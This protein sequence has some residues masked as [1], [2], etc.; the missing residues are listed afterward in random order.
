MRILSSLSQPSCVCACC[1]FEGS[2]RV[3]DG[4]LLVVA[5]IMF[6]RFVFGTGNVIYFFV[7]ILVV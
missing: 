3:V 4:S 1:P 6:G 7:S 5:T 2:D